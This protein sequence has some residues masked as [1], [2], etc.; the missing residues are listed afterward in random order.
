MRDGLHAPPSQRKFSG[1][2]EPCAL[3]GD[4]TSEHCHCH[5]S[6][7]HCCQTTSLSLRGVNFERSSFC[8]PRRCHFSAAWQP[9]FSVSGCLGPSLNFRR[10][11]SQ[12]L[13]FAFTVFAHG[14]WQELLAVRRTLTTNMLCASSQVE[15]DLGVDDQL[16]FLLSGTVSGLFARAIGL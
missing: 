14:R 2:F 12:V 7:M 5:C 4:R 13:F 11:H 8:Q 15:R 10:C 9:I 16:L 1:Q 3:T 6:F